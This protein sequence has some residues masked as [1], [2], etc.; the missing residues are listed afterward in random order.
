MNQPHSRLSRKPINNIDWWAWI[1]VVPK[2]CYCDWSMHVSA[3]RYQMIKQ[4]IV[5]CVLLHHKLELSYTILVYCVVGSIMIWSRASFLN[6]SH[7][8]S[9]N[10]N[11]NNSSSKYMIER[12]A[13]DQ[14]P[15]VS[16]TKEDQTSNKE[17][18]FPKFLSWMS[19]IWSA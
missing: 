6:S 5:F 18:P 9:S 3:T 2:F 1:G 14:I 8:S 13:I 10:N 7:N 12:A 11:N 19:T 16:M 15:I 17:M 4:L